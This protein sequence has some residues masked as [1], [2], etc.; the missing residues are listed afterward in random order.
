MPITTSIA[1]T[2]FWRLV[3]IA[4]MCVVFGVWGVY[5][6]FVKIPNQE[7]RYEEFTR[8]VEERG[9]FDAL[10]E[11]YKAEGR[12][13]TEEEVRRFQ[14]NEQRLQI[15]APGG[16]PPTRP[17]KFNRL[18]QWIYIACLPCAPYFVV[19][20]KR[21]TRQRYALDDE[22]TLSFEGDP[23]LGSGT[24]S[25][26]Q[27]ADIDMSIW[28]K[29]S[30]A[31]AVHADGTRLKLDAYVHK[32]LELIIGAIASRLY[33]DEWTAEAKPIKRGDDNIQAGAEA[34]AADSAAEAS[35]EA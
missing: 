5:D 33:P 29:K 27:I 13:P 11:K 18:T 28:M 25:K 8:L 9:Q 19:L 26:D 4:G 31:H 24:W 12:M 16:K 30:I 23:Q 34:V 22:G 3:L 32:N 2:Y 15:V 17:S 7:Q 14:E 21:S 20:L 10:R 1:P 6:L 35:A